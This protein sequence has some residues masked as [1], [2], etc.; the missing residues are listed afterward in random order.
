MDLHRT[1]GKADWEAVKPINRNAFQK[2]AAATGGIITPANFVT[3]LGLALTAYGLVLIT[4]KYFWLALV[5]LGVGRLLDIA[6]G[7]V[8]DGTQTK[9][10]VGEMLDASVDKVV[11]L[12]TAVVLIIA[13]VAPWW[14]IAALILPHVIIPFVVFYKKLHGIKIHPS[15]QGKLSMA[16]AW[17]GIGGLIVLQAMPGFEPLAAVVYALIGASLGLGLYALWQYSTGRD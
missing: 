3:I 12:L 10:P 8:A 5:I 14:V 16:T 9:S 15:R 13:D 7:Y 11:T 2:I 6:D 17:F 1:T 4:Q